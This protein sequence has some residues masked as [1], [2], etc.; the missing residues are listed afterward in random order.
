[1]AITASVLQERIRDGKHSVAELMQ[2]GKT[3][4][5]R[6]HVLPGVP[7]LL[8]EVMVEGTFLDGS[9]LVTVHD[10]ICTSHGSLRDALYGSFLPVPARSV[11][12]EE[13]DSDEHLPGQIVVA[14][15]SNIILSKDSP[16]M[17]FKV[18]NT[19]DRP[20]QVGS[21]YPFHET[22]PALLFPRLLAIGYRLDIAA[23]TAVRFEPGDVKTVSLVRIG[24]S[25]VVAGGN[26]IY[27]GSLAKLLADASWQQTIKSRLHTA[28]FID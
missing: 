25:Q 3:L 7:E 24:G 23:G 12:K 1:M 20:I 9:F 16:R 11:F 19:G 17:A 27:S 15:S 6:A 4:L 2:H 21:H 26:G 28:N 18:T 13:E 10:P 5:G 8:H 22:N 14:K